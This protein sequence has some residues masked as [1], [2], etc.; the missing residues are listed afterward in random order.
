MG[1]SPRS[2][3]A[4]AA[5]CAEAVSGTAVEALVRREDIVVLAALV[6]LIV[7][8]WLALFTGAGTGMDPFAMSRVAVTRDA[9]GGRPGLDAL[10]LAHRVFHVGGDD[11]GDDAAVG[12][13][14][15][16]ALCPR[17]AP[18]RGPGPR[19]SRARRHPRLRLR[20][21]R[22]LDSFQPV[23]GHGSVGA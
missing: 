9:A 10:L 23:G 8:A 12:F 19:P 20:L 1:N 13:P 18:G 7:L 3:S 16:A 5:W 11:G 15:G 22:H 2:I 4:R 6:V 21:P 17:R 14:H